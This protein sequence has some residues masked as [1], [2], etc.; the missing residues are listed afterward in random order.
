MRFCFF[1]FSVLFNYGVFGLFVKP[2]FRAGM[3][4]ASG[5]VVV[6]CHTPHFLG[7]PDRNQ[8]SAASSEPK[9][10]GYQTWGKF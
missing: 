4:G 1:T 5:D 6:L 10:A 7:P 9:L 8:L 3:A 2:G